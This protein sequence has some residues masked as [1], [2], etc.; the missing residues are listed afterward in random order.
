MFRLSPFF[1]TLISTCL[2][3]R[4]IRRE[5]AICNPLV[6]F[7]IKIGLFGFSSLRIR[8]ASCPVFGVGRLPCIFS[9][10]SREISL[11]IRALLCF[12]GFIAS[13]QRGEEASQPTARSYGTPTFKAFYGL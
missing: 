4:L 10:S 8:W 6:A 13:F 7:S 12:C 2:N 5:S 3:S 1:S 11:V 9:Y